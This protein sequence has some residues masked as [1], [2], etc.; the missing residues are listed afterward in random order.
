MRQAYSLA[1]SS[2]TAAICGRVARSEVD[3]SF[4]IGS[5]G[6]GNGSSISLTIGVILRI[7]CRIAGYLSAVLRR[8]GV[9]GKLERCRQV[10]DNRRGDSD[11]D[12]DW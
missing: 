2:S 1:K 11:D 3:G 4:H 8:S 12:A 5:V 9:P 10:S 6:P 7:I